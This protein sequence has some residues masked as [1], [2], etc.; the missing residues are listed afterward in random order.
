MSVDKN[1]NIQMSANK[2]ANVRMSFLPIDRHQNLFSKILYKLDCT[3]NIVTK[4]MQVHTTVS[5]D[6][7]W[8]FWVCL[9]CVTSRGDT[10]HTAWP[11]RLAMLGR[12]Y[13]S[14]VTYISI[15]YGLV[16]E[17]LYIKVVKSW[18]VGGWKWKVH[19]LS[20]SKPCWT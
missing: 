1:A 14:R 2:K 17:C 5:P 20:M 7:Y 11:N 4:V 3:T 19:H 15:F 10:S 12:S 13:A 9:L 6:N 18:K 8:F 16:K